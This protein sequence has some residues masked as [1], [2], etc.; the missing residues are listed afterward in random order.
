MKNPGNGA[1]VF[2]D[3]GCNLCSREIRYYRKLDKAGKICWQDISADTGLLEAFGVSV[4][5]AM[6]RFHVLDSQGNMR[7]GAPA[8]LAMWQELPYFSLLSRFCYAC[9]LVPALNWA[10]SHFAKWRYRSRS[11]ALCH[12]AGQ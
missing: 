7:I 8:F 10:Y 11:G 9:H 2:Y 1:I 4:D 12:L 5:D 3:G 6:R